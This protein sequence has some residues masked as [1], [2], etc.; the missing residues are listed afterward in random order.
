MLNVAMIKKRSLWQ[1]D[2]EIKPGEDSGVPTSRIPWRV[3]QAHS[4]HP[5][6]TLTGV[7]KDLGVI[8]LFISQ[9]WWTE[10]LQGKQVQLSLCVWPAP[11][12]TRT[13]SLPVTQMVCIVSI[14][15]IGSN[16]LNWWTIL[17][18]KLLFLKNPCKGKQ[19]T[20]FQILLFN[21]IW[22]KYSEQAL[23]LISLWD[24]LMAT[25]Y[26]SQEMVNRKQKMSP[27]SLSLFL[28]TDSTNPLET[29]TSS[30]SLSKVEPKPPLVFQRRFRGGG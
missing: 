25:W 15:V 17:I 24:M 6:L 10:H 20:S 14:L 28:S 18:C 3:R 29:C 30:C 13:V 27:D 1:D 19:I 8:L 12:G 11:K 9:W 21:L 4:L 2:R 22:L 26:P 5:F 23:L 16:F 7:V